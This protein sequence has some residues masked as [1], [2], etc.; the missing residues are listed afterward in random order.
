MAGYIEYNEEFQLAICRSCRVR[1]SSENAIP[2][3]RRQHKQSWKERGK[4]IKRYIET[5]TLA[6]QADLVQPEEP[7]LW[8]FPQ[9]APC[10]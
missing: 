3:M 2:H 9:G 4:D 5:L 10:A 1:L 7:Y 8:R 6:D